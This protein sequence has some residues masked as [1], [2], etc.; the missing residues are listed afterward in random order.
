MTSHQNNLFARVDSMRSKS[1]E[2]EADMKAARQAKAEENRR[3]MPT[4]A[5]WVDEARAIFGDDVKVV[6]AS[7]GGIMMGSPTKGGIT[8]LETSANGS[9]VLPKSRGRK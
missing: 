2:R 8:L 6:Y 5:A 4:V 9:F 7:E 1:A 3:R